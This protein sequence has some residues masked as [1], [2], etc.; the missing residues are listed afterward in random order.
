[1][2]LSLLGQ[3]DEEGP[4]SSYE[5][6]D[7]DIKRRGLEPPVSPADL[8]LK[9]RRSSMAHDARQDYA[10]RPRGWRP[11]VSTSVRVGPPPHQATG[12]ALFHLRVLRPVLLRLPGP[13]RLCSSC[14]VPV[15]RSMPELGGGQ[16]EEQAMAARCA[17]EGKE[18]THVH[19]RGA[20]PSKHGPCF[21]PSPQ[22][23][24]SSLNRLDPTTSLATPPDH[25]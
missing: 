18:Q 11:Y 25:A 6:V 19:C 1:M 16:R 2:S 15:S 22:A 10:S 24:K 14:F 23:F 17:R 3:A 4:G 5:A 21:R 12:R 13:R 20:G 8:R 9:F 7:L